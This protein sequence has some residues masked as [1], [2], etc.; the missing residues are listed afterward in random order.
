MMEKEVTQ[1]L[2]RPNLADIFDSFH[3]TRLKSSVLESV[4]RSAYGDEYP[5]EAR[6]NAFF[7]RTTLL[8]LLTALRVA[9]GQ[10]VVD[11]GCGH[12]GPGLWVAQQSGAD[13]IGIDLSAVGVA[14]A[15]ERA[16]AAGLSQ[17]AR[18]HVG[19]IAATAL[20]DASCDAAMSLDV[21]LF[22]PDKAA[23]LREVARILPKDGSF[24]FTTWEQPGHS[25]RLGAA[26]LADY[27]PVLEG[28][29]FEIE[30]YE[31]PL[32]WRGQQRPLLEGIIAVQ[33][34]LAEEIGAAGAAGWVAMA[35]GGLADLSVRRYVF[36]VAGKR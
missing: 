34:Q 10:T 29:G 19:D 5:E 20:P 13:L 12:G 21:L 35:R 25:E 11:L 9:S 27:R 1:P 17:R 2:S 3:A 36:G 24:A 26:Q 7:S 28:A 22:A 6:A 32:N 14:L 33:A 31:E 4:Y 8:Q 23:A 15:Q 30:I 18:F 16:V